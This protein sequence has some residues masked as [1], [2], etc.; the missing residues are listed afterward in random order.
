MSERVRVV[1]VDDHVMV[2]E[3]LC[4]IL[5]DTGKIQV[6]GQAGDR[7]EALNAVRVGAPTVLVLDYNLP[8]GGALPV[9]AHVRRDHPDV[10]ILI[11]TVHES[12]HYALHALEAGAHG[13]S[14]KR[15]A[16]RELEDAIVAL[17]RGETWVTPALSQ[18]VIGALAT[19][20]GAR[21]GIASLS[22][23]E[24]EILSLLG[25]GLGLQAAAR[26]QG[27]STS[28]ASTYR[29]RVMEKLG[30]RTTAELIRFAIESGLTE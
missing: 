12:V 5:E 21:T 29:T 10:R 4:H 26:S 27:V 9:I 15:A 6:V 7:R 2:R 14:I 20:Q 11:L 1:L 19:K 24:F 22:T 30:L 3:A 8:G 13:F 25:S 28:T 18:Q 23:R 16:M 17:A